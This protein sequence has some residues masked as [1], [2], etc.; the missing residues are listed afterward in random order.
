MNMKLYNFCARRGIALLLVLAAVAM[1]TIFGFAL[2]SSTSLQA[3]VGGNNAGSTSADYLAESGLQTGMYFLQYP[4]RMPAGWDT[5]PGYVLHATNQSI[6]ASALGSLDVS[7]TTTATRDVY[8][9]AA[10]GRSPDGATSRSVTAQ[11]KVDRAKITG[12]AYFGGPV[13]LPV[14]TVVTG[15]VQANGA[16]TNNTG[17]A[18]T[19]TTMAPLAAVAFQTPSVANVNW[20]GADG[21]G[22]YV[23]P[24]GITG[25]AQQLLAA[26]SSPPIPAV[27]NPGKIYYY[28]GD[29]TLT[30]PVTIDGTLIIKNGTLTIRA[31]GVNVRPVAGFPALIIEKD[32]S[33]YRTAVSLEADG[34]VFVGRNIVWTGPSN[35]GSTLKIDGALLM[36][37]GSVVN[38]PFS[39][40]LQTIAYTAGQSDVS[41]LHKTRQPGKNVKILS[42]NQ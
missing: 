39:G 41:D 20:Y 25:Q 26:P 10:I 33:M 14:R 30:S 21:G 6:G 29:L 24:D 19:G 9:I 7:A 1:A 15:Q 5:T 18:L 2:L 40:G 42:W 32:L 36:P 22:S 16:I 34:S 37:A 13:I 31:S 23:T 28:V 4:S 38:A 17:T 8:D 27:N 12:A 3:Q 35:T 11:V